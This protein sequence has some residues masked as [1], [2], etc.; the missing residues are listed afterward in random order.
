MANRAAMLGQVIRS[1]ARAAAASDREL[2]WR[3]VEERDQAAFSALVRRHT[4]MVLG[5]CQRALSNRQDAEDACQATFL[6]L[7][8][9]ANVE[10]WQSSIANWLYAAA[11][12]VAANARIAAQRRARREGKAAQPEAVQPVDQ[13][14]GRELLAMLDEELDRL[15]DRYR[16]P[17]VL[18]CLEGLTRD[19]AASRLGI[20]L[21]TLKIRLER[22]RKRLGERLR[23]RGCALGAGLLALAV[24]SPAGAAPPGLCEAIMTAAAGQPSPA[25]TAL[26][27]EVA[28]KGFVQK[29]LLLAVAVAAVVAV[30]MG[31]GTASNTAAS[32]APEPPKA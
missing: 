11:R 17:L 28:T 23:L 26:F 4:P 9:K 22:G 14:S 19:E 21:G 5:V 6:L 12:K 13:I 29:S 27:E 10:R 7:V 25:V 30:G 8:K 18:C 20:P 16:E 24:T 3:F 1:V 32:P 31:M 2:L 15:P